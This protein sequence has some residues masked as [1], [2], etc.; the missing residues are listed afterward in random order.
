MDGAGRGRDATEVDSSDGIYTLEA[1]LDCRMILG[2]TGGAIIGIG[3]GKVAIDALRSRRL[4]SE[5]TLR[6]SVFGGGR[7]LFVSTA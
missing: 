7:A 2:R 3:G 1:W 6:G 4:F 5:R